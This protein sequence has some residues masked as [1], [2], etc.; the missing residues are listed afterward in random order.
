[1]YAPYPYPN[2]A[3]VKALYASVREHQISRAE[4]AACI[5]SI[6]GRHHV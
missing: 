1:M 4:F 2:K 5:I 3:L 6:M